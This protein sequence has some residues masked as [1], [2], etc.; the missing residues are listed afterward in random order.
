MPHIVTNKRKVMIL[1]LFKPLLFR[2]LFLAGECN[3]YKI[4]WGTVKDGRDMAKL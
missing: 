4:H 2:S 1:H 3:S